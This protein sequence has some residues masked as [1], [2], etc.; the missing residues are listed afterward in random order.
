MQ[1]QDAQ[2]PDGGGGAPTPPTL[3]LAGA[4]GSGK[5]TVARIL[6]SLGCVVA[7]S[8]DIAHHA[9][10]DPVIRRQL[11]AWWGDRVR[12]CHG[13]HAEI[14]GTPAPVDRNRI[15]AIVFDAPAERAR[16]EALLHPWIAKRRSEIFAAAPPGTRALVIDAP[17]LFE[18]GLDAQCSAVIFVDSPL[19]TRLAR[20]HATRGWSA[21]LHL[22]VFIYIFCIWKLI[23]LIRF[24]HHRLSPIRYT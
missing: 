2:H 23:V 4:P 7:D 18:V 8:D 11:L 19:E 17:L 14:N 20:V 3:G 21:R 15:A 22:R 12:D 10:N 5:S 9:Y 16:L 6:A 1:A 13:C 24:H